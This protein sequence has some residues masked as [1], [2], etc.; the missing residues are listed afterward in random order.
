[1]GAVDD[2][3]ANKDPGF[4]R[5]DDR[6]A[7]ERFVRDNIRWMLAVAR[8]V[9]RDAAAAEDAVQGAFV[10]IFRNIEAFEG[11]FTVEGH[12][13]SSLADAKRYALKGG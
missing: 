2:A 12:S 1:M 6:A 8:R 10:S 4:P 7:T 3:P 9:L 13:F 11:R 5:A